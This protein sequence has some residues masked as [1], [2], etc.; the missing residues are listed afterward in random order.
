M[1]NQM[2]A[3]RLQKL[4]MMLSSDN[5]GEVV[6]AAR[7]IGKALKPMGL[8]WHKLAARLAG[9][10]VEEPKAQRPEPPRS[11]QRW[12]AS[13]FTDGFMSAQEQTM[14][15][16]CYGAE[17]FKIKPNERDF[18]NQLC[19]RLDTYGNSTFISAKQRAWLRAIHAKV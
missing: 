10:K 9:L 6:N 18:I 19:A 11:G 1:V 16:D 13:Q 2:S 4:V 12:D 5:D 8:D 3:E 7:M 17:M 15:R 14:A